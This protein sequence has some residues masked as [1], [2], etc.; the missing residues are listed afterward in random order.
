MSNNIITEHTLSIKDNTKTVIEE[1]K[2]K[3]P[4]IFFKSKGDDEIILIEN[5]SINSGIITLLVFKKNKTKIVIPVGDILNAGQLIY[6]YKYSE[7]IFLSN[8]EEFFLIGG[9]LYSSQSQSIKLANSTTNSPLYLAISKGDTIS[10]LGLKIKKG[11]TVI[12]NQKSGNI[13]FYKTEM[14]KKNNYTVE[15]SNQSPD[16]FWSGVVLLAIFET[17]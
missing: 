2:T 12:K 11:N 15:Y 3:S 14:N 5:S 1:K 7:N 13:I 9:N 8:K 10:T 6:N 16:S 17:R 4:L